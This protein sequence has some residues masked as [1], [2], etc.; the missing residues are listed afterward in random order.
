MSIFIYI[1]L[2]YEFEECF[3]FALPHLLTLCMN[4]RRTIKSPVNCPPVQTIRYHNLLISWYE[5]QQII[6][7]LHC[8]HIECKSFN[9]NIT[10]GSL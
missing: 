1:S 5:I 7:K 2:L 10:L 8:L 3:V 9:R 4:N 6:L